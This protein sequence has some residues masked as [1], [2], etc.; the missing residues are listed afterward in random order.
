MQQRMQCNG[1]IVGLLSLGVLA[2]VAL[3]TG[4]AQAQ[5]TSVWPDYATPSWNQTLPSAHAVHHSLKFRRRSGAGS[6]HRARLGEVPAD[7]DRHVE[8][9]PLHLHQQE[10]RRSERVAPAVHPRAG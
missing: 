6:E 3:T 10:R 1:V 7:G 8:W 9:R 2:T 5:T 4:P